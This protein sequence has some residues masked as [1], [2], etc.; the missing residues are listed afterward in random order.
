MLQRFDQVVDEH[1][2]DVYS[3]AFYYLGS[4]QEAEDI[5]Q[6]VF[7]RLWR[8]WQRV[9]IESIPR[10]LNRVTRNACFDE[11]RRR[12]RRR[13][14]E[15][16]EDSSTYDETAPA[17]GTDPQA[18]AETQ[19]LARRLRRTLSQI[20]EPYRSVLIMRDV[21][22]SCTVVGAPARIVKLNGKRV[23]LPLERTKEPEQAGE[24]P[25]PEATRD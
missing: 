3:F 5:T 16:G 23:D 7:L 14:W 25:D 22:E 17:E 13:T 20:P 19:E 10:W 1:K 15:S 9:E 2:D 11:L 12:R 4:R 6:E 21:P 8:S 18:A 24:P